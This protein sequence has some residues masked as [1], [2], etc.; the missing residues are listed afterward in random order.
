MMHEIVARGPPTLRARFRHTALWRARRSGL[1]R[2]AAI[3]LGNRGEA[4]AVPAVRAALGDGDASV[5][6]AAAWA[7]S[8]LTESA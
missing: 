4:A 8:R 6:A 2:N 5:R 3:V 1:L 7:L